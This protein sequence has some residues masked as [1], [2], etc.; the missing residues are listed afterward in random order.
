[1]PLRCPYTYESGSRVRLGELDSGVRLGCI[2]I[3]I[4]SAQVRLVTLHTRTSLTHWNP[5]PAG[6]ASQTRTCMGTLRDSRGRQTSTLFLDLGN[7]RGEGSASRPDRFLPPVKT[8]YPLYRRLCGPQ[9]GQ[10]GKI[11]SPTGI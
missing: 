3:H 10:V 5:S 2:Y 6:L 9:S 8:R 4:D 7:R 1:M 11:S